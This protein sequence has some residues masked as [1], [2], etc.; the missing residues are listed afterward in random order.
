MRNEI[1]KL[2]K[3]EGK[4]SDKTLEELVDY[5]R[6]YGAA[7]GDGR[8]KL[9]YSHSMIRSFIASIAASHLIILQGLSGTGK[10]SLPRL[11]KKALNFDNSLIPVQTYCCSHIFI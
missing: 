8:T 6:N 7:I 5:V 11:M 1:I 4:I 2:L 3:K 10:S 9:Y